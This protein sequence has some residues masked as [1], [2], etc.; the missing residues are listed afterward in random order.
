M[1]G[2]AIGHFAVC[3]ATPLLQRKEKNRDED[4]HMCRFDRQLDTRLWRS[5]GWNCVVSQNTMSLDAR[6]LSQSLLTIFSWWRFRSS[7]YSCAY[8]SYIHGAILVA[9]TVG[10]SLQYVCR[11]AFCACQ[12]IG[13]SPWETDLLRSA[14]SPSPSTE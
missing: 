1:H 14:S 12:P 6:N 4:S 3:R 7:L 9:P 8:H 2:H 10:F 13:Y 5:P 11:L